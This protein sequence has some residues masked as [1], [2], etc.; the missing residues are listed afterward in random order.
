MG[1]LYAPIVKG[2]ENDLK[3]VSLLGRDWSSTKPLIEYT[4]P[5][6]GTDVAA[7]LA[8]FIERIRRYVALNETFVDFYGFHPGTP[9]IDDKHPIAFAFDIV[10][11]YGLP[12]TPVMGF[13]REIEVARQEKLWRD[14]EP[15]FRR[16][17][18]GL[19]FRVDIEDIE[20]APEE[21]WEQIVERSAQLHLRPAEV[22]VVM[23]LRSLRERDE[24][25]VKE[26][27]IDFAVGARSFIPRSLIL[28][29][30]SA[31]QTVSNVPEDGGVS[32]DRTELRLWA[33]LFVDAA[34]RS[35][36]TFGDYGVVYPDFDR[37]TLAT[38]INAK[39]RYTARDKIHYFR[40]QS[41][42][43]IPPEQQYPVLARRVVDSPVYADPKYS[44]GDRYIYECAQGLESPRSA[45]PWVFADQ[46][47]HL[48]HTARQTQELVKRLRG[49]EL[50]RVGLI[51]A[52]EFG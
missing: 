19:C 8:G 48:V 27:V 41:Y 39:I 32:I 1:A 21:T 37:D 51:L 4:L 49:A 11:A 3:A 36:L 25:A 35:P 31:L 52:S 42:S 46:N 50:D 33:E 44:F 15:L 10:R 26:L 38:R 2:H 30:S 28:A 24:R 6:P 16:L 43:K 47:R 14:V 7:D 23:D 40:G 22:D 12:V 18:R 9:D 34:F 17:G 29:G 5:K 13:D 45:G 20:G